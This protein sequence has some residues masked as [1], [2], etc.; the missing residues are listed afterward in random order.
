MLQLIEL[1][2]ENP[3]AY[4]KQDWENALTKEVNKILNNCKEENENEINENKLTALLSKEL[5]GSL[6]IHKNIHTLVTDYQKLGNKI[7]T[8]YNK[9]YIE[10]EKL[11]NDIDNKKL[12]SQDT[13]TL[14][15][16][17]NT[18]KGIMTLDRLLFKT[19]QEDAISIL[20]YMK[21]QLQNLEEDYKDTA[22][23]ELCRSLSTKA[24]KLEKNLKHITSDE[25][26]F[27]S[28]L[29]ALETNSLKL[30]KL[31]NDCT[32]EIKKAHHNTSL[33]GLHYFFSFLLILTGIL[34][35]LGIANL[36]SKK[37]KGVFL[38]FNNNEKLNKVYNIT[39]N[40]T[41]IDPAIDPVRVAINF[42]RQNKDFFVKKN[43]DPVAFVEW[44]NTNNQ[45]DL[46]S[47]YNATLAQAI[48]SDREDYIDAISGASIQGL[49][50]ECFEYGNTIKLKKFLENHPEF[51]KA[52]NNPE[53][54]PL[55]SKWNQDNLDEANITQG[56]GE[57]EVVST[58]GTNRL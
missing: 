24:E 14:E 58:L 40:V 28:A 4:D 21:K 15:I 3:S 16:R 10:S 55:I 35:P 8:D 50:K 20:S 57:N 45:S 34:A 11:V 13:N 41:N 38:F 6:Y 2:L 44:G 33:N 48:G 43:N 19:L 23:V 30:R 42:M 31:Q 18:L 52:I 29:I 47:N 37:Q 49:N 7:L 26:F 5:E 36:V 46:V 39:T 25:D 51:V 9:R 56:E 54:H 1:I 32:D 27:N 22:Y 53:F 12:L 17:L